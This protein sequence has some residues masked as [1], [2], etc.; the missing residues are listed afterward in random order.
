MTGTDSRDAVNEGGAAEESDRVA[1]DAFYRANY[2]RLVDA[3]RFGYGYH[4]EIAKEGA[5]QA[6]LVMLKELPKLRHKPTHEQ[7]AYVAKVAVRAA[8]DLRRKDA[9]A[10]G[11]GREH[12]VHWADPRSPKPPIHQSPDTAVGQVVFEQTLAMLPPQQRRV[13]ALSCVGLSSQQIADIL[14]I[15]IGNV[16]RT[17]KDARDSL[18]KLLN[19]EDLR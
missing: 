6:L 4:E 17:A 2:S 14:G 9:A 7:Q 12:E 1:F 3:L 8:A 18:R 16:H 13:M 5:Q 19:K 11:K 15:S 10:V